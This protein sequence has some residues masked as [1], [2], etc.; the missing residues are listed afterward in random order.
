MQ[1]QI[2]FK[3]LP[4]KVIIRTS[5]QTK[6]TIVV[7]DFQKKRYEI[8]CNNYNVNNNTQHFRSEYRKA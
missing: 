5:L 2:V 6:R 8:S 4:F 3:N 1:F 7:F